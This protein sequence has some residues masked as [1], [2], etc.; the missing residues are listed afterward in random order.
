MISNDSGH[1]CRRA[2]CVSLLGSLAPSRSEDLGLNIPTFLWDQQRFHEKVSESRWSAQQMDYIDGATSE[3]L[4]NPY[5][6]A[7]DEDGSLFVAS[8]THNHIVRM[9][10][11]P[12]KTAKWKIFA[13][14]TEM[15]SPVGMVVSG[16]QLFVASF[17]NDRI[18]RVDTNNGQLIDTFGNEDQLDCPEGIALG[19]G[20][21]HLYVASFLLKHIVR[22]EL[23]SGAYLGQFS[24]SGARP[25][26]SAAMLHPAAPQPAPPLNGAEV[27]TRKRRP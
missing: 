14:G 2:W 25:A 24:E 16:G 8:F 19:P 21:S 27:R 20:G 1:M 12:G 23:S 18:L 5:T 13:S 11:G 6:L 22:Y 4:K 26:A 9:R 15:D 7:F 17:T 3:V 10:M